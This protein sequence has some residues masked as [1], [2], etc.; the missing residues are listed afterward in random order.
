[1][2]YTFHLRQDVTWHDGTPFTADDVV[3]TFDAFS[4]PD[5]GSARVGA[6]VATVG[7]YTKVDDHTVTVV[8]NSVMPQ[9]VFLND[10]VG[11]VV[12]KHIW[13][14]V[15]FADW[16]FDGG[17]T[18]AD[19]SR[20]IGTGPFQIVE[21]NESDQTVTLQRYDGYY[22][23]VATID[24]IVLSIW[25]D[26]T[27]AVEALRAGQIDSIIAN[28]PPAEAIS[29][30][31]EGEVRITVYDTFSFYFAAYNLNPERTTLFQDVQTRQALM[32][33]LDRESIVNDIM[34]GYAIVAHGPQPVLS[35]GYAPDEM[36][37]RYDYDVEKAKALLAEAGWAD[38]DGDGILDRDGV[39]F[40]FSFI[41]SIGNQSEDQIVAYMADAW[42]ELG[43]SMTPEPVDFSTVL[44]GIVTGA[45]PTFDYEMLGVG[46]TWDVSGDQSRMFHSSAYPGQF[47][48]PMYSNPAADAALEAASA[49]TDVAARR[50][51]L[52][53]ASNIINDDIP[54]QILYFSKGIV[55]SS[56]R[57]NNYY[58]SAAGGWWFLPYVWFT[59]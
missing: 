13:E 45:N 59:A 9:I 4:S 29:L 51:L 52:I 58:P 36:R 39:K 41:Y 37:T 6:F 1:V 46:F 26:L 16:Q 31:E 8:A 28:V 43:I 18:G 55:G 49:T 48:I 2:T 40:E 57:L 34:L 21:V 20:I 38:T 17:K 56:M 24:Q 15:P 11:R 44:L 5:L 12:A 42:S 22:G 23:K 14:S 32:Y 54:S 33:A 35:P 30:E 10:M 47:N 25:P 27:S 53:E 19:T 7:S 50:Q 3:L